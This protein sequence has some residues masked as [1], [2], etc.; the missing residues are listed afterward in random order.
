[1]PITA[2]ERMVAPGKETCGR[3]LSERDGPLV[4][5]AKLPAIAVGL[6][7]VIAENLVELDQRRPVDGEP[8]GE[9]LV[10]LGPVAFGNA[11]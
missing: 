10:Q 5:R 7:E 11:S 1:M 6:L 3:L 2:L 8:A 4:E 9:A